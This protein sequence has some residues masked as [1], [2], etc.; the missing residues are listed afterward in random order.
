MKT[1]VELW[2]GK[3]SRYEY[4]MVFGRIEY[5]HVNEWK[6]HPRTKKCIFLEYPES[7]KDTSCGA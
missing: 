2:Y 7:V 6:L 1:P 3:P 4:L 5:V